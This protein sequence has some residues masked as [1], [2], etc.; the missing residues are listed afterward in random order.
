MPRGL[1]IL[2]IGSRDATLQGAGAVFWLALLL[3]IAM[4]CT[5]AVLGIPALVDALIPPGLIAAQAR[6]EAAPDAVVLTLRERFPTSTYAPQVLTP[7][8][9][10]NY[11]DWLATRIDYGRAARRSRH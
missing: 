8:A 7:I 2:S 5:R 4:G 1:L 6:S 3:A 10:H 11:P 9:S